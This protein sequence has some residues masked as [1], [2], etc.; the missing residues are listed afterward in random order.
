MAMLLPY[1]GYSLNVEAVPGFEYK[2]G[3]VSGLCF[4]AE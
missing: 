4:K 2:V 1:K 3:W